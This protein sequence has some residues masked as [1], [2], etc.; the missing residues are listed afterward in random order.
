[1][2]QQMPANVAF[3]TDAVERLSLSLDQARADVAWLRR[4]KDAE[5][6]AVRI[7]AELEAA[8]AEL[9]AATAEAILKAREAEFANLR[10]L[11]VTVVP[12]DKSPGSIIAATYKIS[13]EQ[14]AYDP[15]EKRSTWQPRTVNGFSALGHDVYRYLM[16]AKP[17]AIPPCIL[18][19]APDGDPDEAMQA[20]FVAM[21]RG[22]TSTPT[23]N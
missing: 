4:L 19:L 20:Y 1:M 22:Y 7:S 17:D 13:F 9:A 23:L 14:L 12:S 6:D 15:S 16:L 18:A 8:Q 10:H 11:S 5:K 21:Q 2:T 3:L